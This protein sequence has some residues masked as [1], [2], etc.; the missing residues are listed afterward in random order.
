M[1]DYQQQQANFA[2][3]IRN[4]DK[5]AVSDDSIEAR[6]LTIYS[7]LFFNNIEGFLANSFPVLKSLMS[8]ADWLI[9]ARH[10]IEYHQSHSPYFLEIPQEFLQYLQDDTLPFY[11]Q[12][13]NLAGFSQALAHYEWLELALDV[14]QQAFSVAKGVC[15]ADDRLLSMRAVVS[16]LAYP[17]IYAWP[18]HKIC[19]DYMPTAP[20]AE[21][22]C[23]IVYRDRGDE[24]QFMQANPATL[25][26]LE[27][28]QQADVDPETD[29]AADVSSSLLSVDDAITTLANEMGQDKQ[30]IVTFALGLLRQLHQQD[31]ISHF[32]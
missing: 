19:S 9:L 25:R 6:R 17:A 27:L 11:Q 13:P 32:E 22:E 26:L 5:Y 31:I 24:V 8:E 7:E 29:V 16:P 18:V 12:Q 1:F 23:L 20:S 14:A 3:H 28:L 30:A 2:A 4:P 15:P 21:P 10:F